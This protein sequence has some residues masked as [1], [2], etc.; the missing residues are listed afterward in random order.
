M[1]WVPNEGLPE[2]RGVSIRWARKN[3]LGRR[4]W[5]CGVVCLDG[6]PFMVIQN[7]GREG[8]DERY[9]WVFEEGLYVEAVRRLSDRG[10]VRRPERCLIRWR[11]WHLGVMFGLDID[12]PAASENLDKLW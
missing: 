12:D 1:R 3:T 9:A 8:D 5:L 2:P 7:A 10:R 11:Y 4:V 6:A